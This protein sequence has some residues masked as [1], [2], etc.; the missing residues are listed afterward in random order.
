[1]SQ[2]LRGQSQVYQT[3]RPVNADQL[4]TKR[5][6]CLTAGASH[7]GGGLLIQI[8]ENQINQGEARSGCLAKSRSNLELLGKPRH[9]QNKIVA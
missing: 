2:A 1:M 7:G 3:I 8:S 5:W 4:L 6:N 9:Y